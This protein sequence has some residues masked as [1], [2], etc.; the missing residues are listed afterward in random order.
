MDFSPVNEQTRARMENVR[1][2][3]LAEKVAL[4]TGAASG[5]GASVARRLAT[6]AVRIVAADINEQGV[7]TV[8]DAPA[9]H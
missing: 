9:I 5:I 4:V 6:Q 3:S 1:N 8:A 2:R 7:R